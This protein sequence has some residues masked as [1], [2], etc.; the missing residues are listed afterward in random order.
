MIM[1]QPDSFLVVAL[2]VLFADIMEQHF[3]RDVLSED[4]RTLLT[5]EP[6]SNYRQVTDSSLSVTLEQILHVELSVHGTVCIG[7]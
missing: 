4:D 1:F 6:V 2:R 5:E 7:N 3:S